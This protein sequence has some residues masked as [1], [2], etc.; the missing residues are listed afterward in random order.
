MQ[1]NYQ[2]LNWFDASTVAMIAIGVGLVFLFGM[3]SLERRHQENIVS[4][5]NILDMH[6]GW[7]KQ[8]D[9]ATFV[10]SVAFEV[11]QVLLDE[12]YLAF[13]EIAVIPVEQI[14]ELAVIP[15]TFLYA[16]NGGG[17]VLGATLEAVDPPEEKS[18]SMGLR[19]PYE[20][21][22]PNLILPKV[23]FMKVKIY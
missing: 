8:I 5:F 19:M 18:E 23:E 12:A 11:P 9:T 1:T 20:F 13:T 16:Y 2:K 3:G 6:E 7:N 17:K 22:K 15:E 21:E 10:A 4:A 14:T